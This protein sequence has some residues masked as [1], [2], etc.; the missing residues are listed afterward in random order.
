MI[1]F[2]FLSS[3]HLSLVKYKVL[4]SFEPG[5]AREREDDR[6]RIASLNYDT[7]EFHR[8]RLGLKDSN[9]IITNTKCNL[10]IKEKTQKRDEYVSNVNSIL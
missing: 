5:K 1:P 6:C 3:I 10:A 8:P 4:T 7:T 9:V 2:H